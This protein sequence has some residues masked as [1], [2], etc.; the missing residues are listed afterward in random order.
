[1]P[2]SLRTKEDIQRWCIAFVAR[3]L[4]QPEARV[5]PEV[6]LE[7]YGLDSALLVGMIVQLEEALGR[8]I[9]PSILFEQ[10]TISGLASHLAGTPKSP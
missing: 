3:A 8:E 1:M 6:E 5:N 7:S 10:P 4:N 2:A 9:S